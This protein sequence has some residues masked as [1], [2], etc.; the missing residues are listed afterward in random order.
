MAENKLL[1][2]VKETVCK[3]LEMSNGITS[4]KSLKFYLTLILYFIS[5]GFFIKDKFFADTIGDFS[6]TQGSIILFTALV[7]ATTLHWDVLLFGKPSGA[8]FVLQMI[9]F[10]PITLFYSRIMGSPTETI[11]DSSIL[12]E[13]VQ[14]GSEAIKSFV[15]IDFSGFMSKISALFD[16]RYSIIMLILILAAFSFRSKKIKVSA[17]VVLLAFAFFSCLSTPGSRLY[18]IGGLIFMIGGL[19]LQFNNYAQQVYYLNI[20]NRLKKRKEIGENHLRVIMRVM[21]RAD[22]EGEVLENEVLDIVESECGREAAISRDEIRVLSGR[23]LQN[24]MNEFNLIAIKLTH[25][26]IAASVNCKL[27]NCDNFLTYIA[28]LPRV[29][30]VLGIT[31]IFLISPIDAIPDAMPLVGVLDDMSLTILSFFMAKNSFEAYREK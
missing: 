21:E 1:G 13:L 14:K 3:P 27:Y 30:M 4:F 2:A 25:N 6:Y 24:M 12:G 5:A 20:I 19:A 8:N 15:G 23:I 9:S 7:I 18:L 11:R 29:L 17:L 22:E 16:S 26:G 31:V 10:V 28:I